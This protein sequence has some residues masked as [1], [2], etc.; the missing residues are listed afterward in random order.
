MA[1]LAE[2]LDGVGEAGVVVVACYD[3]PRVRREKGDS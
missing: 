3:T 2:M 1:R